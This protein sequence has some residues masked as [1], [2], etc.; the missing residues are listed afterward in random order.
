M[1]HFHFNTDGPRGR[2]T[3]CQNPAESAIL[4]KKASGPCGC[5]LPNNSIPFGAQNPPS[6]RYWACFQLDPA[7][8]QHR[9]WLQQAALNRAAGVGDVQGLGTGTSGSARGQKLEPS[10]S[11]FAQLGKLNSQLWDLQ[12]R[13]SQCLH[14]VDL[15]STTLEGSC[16]GAWWVVAK[17]L[18]A[19]F[20]LG[21]NLQ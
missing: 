8:W 18:T 12:G 21:L 5:Q 13:N 16:H 2:E 7:T 3:S 11:S 14:Q 20:V 19:Y 10:F 4:Q 6:F 17:L 15:I 1:Q 9:H